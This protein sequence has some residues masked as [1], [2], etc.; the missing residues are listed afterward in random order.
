MSPL[1]VVAIGCTMAIY[2]IIALCAMWAWR[3]LDWWLAV[4]LTAIFLISTVAVV[5]SFERW[6]A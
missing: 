4:P 2:I 5:W 6:G 1:S 3:N